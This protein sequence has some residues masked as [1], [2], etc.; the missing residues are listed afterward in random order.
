[1]SDFNDQFRNFGPDLGATDPEEGTGNVRDEI[2]G[3]QDRP[4]GVR[5]ITTPFER[6][7][8]E[9][10]APPILPCDNATHWIYVINEDYNFFQ[11]QEC[12]VLFSNFPYEQHEIVDYLKHKTN[13]RVVDSAIGRGGEYNRIQVL[14]DDCNVVNAG[15]VHINNLRKLAGA[16]TLPV[17]LEKCKDSSATRQTTSIFKRSWYDT[18]DP[19]FDL[20]GCKYYINIHTSHFDTTNLAS[21]A[22]AARRVGIRRLAQYYGKDFG[23]IRANP[24]YLS[25]ENFAKTEQWYINPDRPGANL[26]FLVGIPA[27]YFDAIPDRE[28]LPRDVEGEANGVARVAVYKSSD[29]RRQISFVASL[30]RSIQEENL[31]WEVDRYRYTGPASAGLGVINFSKEASRLEDLFA[32]IQKILN[33]NDNPLNEDHDHRLEIGYSLGFDIRYIFYDDGSGSRNMIKGFSHYLS[34]EPMMLPRTC[35]YLFYLFEI[36]EYYA[37]GSSI[38]SYKKLLKSYTYPFPDMRPTSNKCLDSFSDALDC[39][40]SGEDSLLKTYRKNR[41]NKLQQNGKARNKFT[42][43]RQ[44]GS[45]RQEDIELFVGADDNFDKKFEPVKTIK[46]I[47]LEEADVQGLQKIMDPKMDIHYDKV[48]ENLAALLIDILKQFKAS[49]S[50][51]EINMKDFNVTFSK[52]ISSFPDIRDL[53][54]DTHQELCLNLDIAISTMKKLGL[55]QPPSYRGEFDAQVLAIEALKEVVSCGDVCRAVPVACGNLDINFPP[56]VKLPE[57]PT[58]DI[59]RA[60]YQQVEKMAVATI[61]D[62]VATMAI[63]ILED[64]TA[65]NKNFLSDDFDFRNNFTNR[66]ED[67]LNIDQIETALVQAEVNIFDAPDGG[68]EIDFE[69]EAEVSIDTGLGE[70]TP[71]DNLGPG[72]GFFRDFNF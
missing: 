46:A 17:S 60:F 34:K 22:A 26:Q 45:R 71:Q 68:D 52:M 16:T 47:R 2:L 31:L 41:K 20:D 1:M 72:Q 70:N 50:F 38:D 36:E 67:S 55:E 5:N 7:V 21:K 51:G 25:D 65:K 15:I 53:S 54:I 23:F 62:N 30:F 19:Y 33:L 11:R 10:N 61:A 8:L 35:A 29:I 37:R 3:G 44:R 66:L 28:V 32:A 42:V 63:N 40:L 27:K 24:L 43:N 64:A 6:R 49:I 69:T 57:F 58:I 39:S 13:V 12:V 56:R 9:Y 59:E 14:D 18:E 48:S 4:G